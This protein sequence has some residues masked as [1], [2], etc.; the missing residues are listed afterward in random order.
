MAVLQLLQHFLFNI[1][2][3]PNFNFTDPA[4]ISSVDDSSISRDGLVLHLD[5]SNWY[6]YPKTGTTWYDISGRGN[7]CS[8]LATAFNST[9]PKYMDFNGSF[10]CAKFTSTDFIPSTT[11]ATV[12]AIIWTRMML[13]STCRTLFRGLSSSANHWVIGDCS[14]WTIGMYNND[15][16]IGYQN[17]GYSQ[18]S[19]P[20]YNTGRWN[21]MVWRYQPASPYYLLTINDTPNVT[22][23]QLTDSRNG[24]PANRGICSIGAYNEANQSNLTLA[25]QFWGD[26]SSVMFYNRI[27]SNSE[28]LE[29]YQSRKNRFGL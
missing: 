1:N 25:S 26:I 15:N 11:T 17:S 5:A 2:V 24:W 7:H 28:L 21:M 18:Q 6:S 9:G 22:S 13:F 10:G 4:F 27:L 14:G 12:T 23:G 3:M 8:V 19:L 16:A 29:N 20:G